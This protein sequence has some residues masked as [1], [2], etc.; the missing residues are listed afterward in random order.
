VAESR[1]TKIGGTADLTHH[2]SANRKKEP[3]KQPAEA[4]LELGILDGGHVAG[5]RTPSYKVALDKHSL[6]ELG[7]RLASAEPVDCYF[8]H[9]VPSEVLVRF[10]EAEEEA[11]VVAS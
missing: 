9:F 6:S 8:T 5:A 7:D 3:R 11:R 10:D 1:S 4:A 2:L